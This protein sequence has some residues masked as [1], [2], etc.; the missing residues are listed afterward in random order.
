MTSSQKNAAELLALDV[1]DV[2][3]NEPL[4]NHGTW[5]IGGPADVLVEPRS[6]DQ[7]VRLR[8][9]IH[10]RG[11]VSIV[12]GEGSNLLFDDAGLRGVCIKIGRSLSG[13]E[14]DPPRV[15]AEA[16]VAV[17][18]LARAVGL[19]GLTG[20]EHTVGIPGTLGGLVVMN[21]GSRRHSLSENIVHVDAMDH[22]GRMHRRLREDC[23][24]VYRGSA[25]QGLDWIVTGVEFELSR[26]DKRAIWR[27]MLEILRD[28]KGKFPRHDAPNCGSVF[29][30]GG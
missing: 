26:G 21:G 14:I 10:E 8:Q 4:R 27:E 5:Q 20:L 6:W 22:R 2:L 23:G 30:S 15:R 19:A 29:V 1:G 9:F 13:F 11:L 3:V 17:P 18:R 25:F 28:R 24:F 16:G 7:L 12:I